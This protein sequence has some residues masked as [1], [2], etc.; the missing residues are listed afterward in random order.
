MTAFLKNCKNNQDFHQ[1]P[2]CCF[3]QDQ[4]LSSGKC[5]AS[6]LSAEYCGKLE[7]HC[8]ATKEWLPSPGL[9]VLDTE[10]FLRAIGQ[11]VEVAVVKAGG[12]MVQ[13]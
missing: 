6:H 1:W 9:G 8:H 3:G 13:P 7:A 11:G 10:F 5:C 2:R 4:N 12:N